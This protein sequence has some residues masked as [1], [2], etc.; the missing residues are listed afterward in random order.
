MAR[1]AAAATKPSWSC[2]TGPSMPDASSFWASCS[3][4]RWVSLFVGSLWRRPS[5]RS[6]GSARIGSIS[7]RRLSYDSQRAWSAWLWAS[8]LQSGWQ[9]P[10]LGRFRRPSLQELF[11]LAFF[12]WCLADATSAAF[13]DSVPF[14]EAYLHYCQPWRS[15]TWPPSL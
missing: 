7:R 3:L 14:S 5:S 6:T 12:S 10:C 11:R 8:S 4:G 15:F 1:I 13:L 9:V 2:S